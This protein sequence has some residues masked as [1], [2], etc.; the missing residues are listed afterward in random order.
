MIIN[1]EI[2]SF[3]VAEECGEMKCYVSYEY[4][5]KLSFLA[6]RLRCIRWLLGG[7]M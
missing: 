1:N 5:V 6:E 4:G 2:S 3:F 7:L